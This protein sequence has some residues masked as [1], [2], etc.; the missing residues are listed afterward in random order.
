[1]FV[2][3]SLEDIS[4]NYMDPHNLL[5]LADDTATVASDMISLKHK[6]LALLA[7]S[8]RN[9]QRANISKTKYLHLSCKPHVEPLQLD[10]TRSIE[11]AHKDGYVYLGMK[12]IT[13]NR[14]K[15]HVTR[16]LNERMGNIYRFISRE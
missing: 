3:K 10:E 9:F 11:S 8:D 15:D 6:I 4:Y 7:Y 12:F 1:M 5:Q 14:M 16:N 13:P 2:A